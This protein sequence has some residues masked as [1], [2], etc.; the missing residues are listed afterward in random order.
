MQAAKIVRYRLCVKTGKVTRETFYAITGLPATAT[1]P[2][3]VAQL[4]RSPWET[5]V[6]RDVRDTVFAEDAPKIRTGHGPANMDT[7]RNFAI[8]TLRTV[9]H[10]SIAAAPAPLL[11]APQPPTRPHRTALTSTD[12]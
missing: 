8:S 12:S 10:H 9:G 5:G 7:L 6:V 1:S 3:F 2:Q 11:P 4:A